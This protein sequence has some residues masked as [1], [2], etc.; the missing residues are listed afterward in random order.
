MSF[1]NEAEAMLTVVNVD[2][3]NEIVWTDDLVWSLWSVD[4]DAISMQLIDWEHV[5]WCAMR[6]EI[7]LAEWCCM[8]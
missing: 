2:M 4:D 5:T 6:G 7:S 3:M 1:K 8:P